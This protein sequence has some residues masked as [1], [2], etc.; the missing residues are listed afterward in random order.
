MSAVADQKPSGP[1]D[2][3]ADAGSK[4][5]ALPP[6]LFREMRMAYR[7]ISYATGRK[8]SP[9]AVYDTE[10]MIFLHVPKNAGSFINGVVYPSLSAETSTA[11]SAHHSAQY[12][13][14][15]NPNKF[16]AYPKFAILR[17]PAA[18]LKS[19]FHY[20]KFSSPFAPDQ[21]F[22]KRELSDVADF[23]TFQSRMAD[24]AF[25]VRMTLPHFRPQTEFICDASGRLMLDDLIT[26]ER[27]SEGM[28]ALARKYGKSWPALETAPQTE[29]P[30][31]L[32]PM[33]YGRVYAGDH[34]LWE[35]AV[36]A[37]DGHY[38]ASV[39]T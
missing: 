27:L 37:P 14:R 23:E 24:P 17:N 33:T 26:L 3:T 21:E 10:S 38:E 7:R 16:R 35:R 19:A 34:A 12:L 13:Y 30:D 4:G 28:S 2:L 15:L 11:I 6:R 22:A 31:E 36:S 1:H 5:A 9:F 32:A 8:T 25:R 18:R 39:S 29:S 20:V